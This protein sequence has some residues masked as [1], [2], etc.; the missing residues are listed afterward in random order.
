MHY[1][2]PSILLAAAILTAAAPANTTLAERDTI[3]ASLNWFTRS[4]CQNSCIEHG[5]C[6][7]SPHEG[8]KSQSTSEWIGWSTGCF[9]RPSNSESISL[10]VN[11]GHKFLAVNQDCA[12]YTKKGYN[13]PDFRSWNLKVASFLGKWLALLSWPSIE[14]AP[15]HW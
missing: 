10:S 8:D 15:V 12:T 13:R 5:L 3:Q 14:S 6:L 11:N 1:L 2:T 9:D 4:D 7:V